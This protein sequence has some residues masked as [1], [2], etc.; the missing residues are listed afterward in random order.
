MN[1]YT[2]PFSAEEI[3]NR[4]NQV[5]INKN[6]IESLSLDTRI[7]SACHASYFNIDKNGI[8]SVKDDVILPDHVFIP[9]HVKGIAVTGMVEGIFKNN[10]DIKE[11]TLCDTITH[12]PNLMCSLAFNLTKINN[13]KNIA[14]I[15]SG[16]FQ[17]TSITELDF[18][19]LQELSIENGSFRNIA[20]LRVIN[21]GDMVQTIPKNTFTNC[22]SLESLKGGQSIIEV[23]ETG[24]KNTPKLKDF[25]QT[26]LSCKAA[27]NS[28]EHSGVQPWDNEQKSAWEQMTFNWD[29]QTQYISQTPITMLD[30]SREKILNSN[31]ESV[32][33][34]IGDTGLTQEYGCSYFSAMHAHSMLQN[35]K[36]NT[37][38]D[39]IND[40]TANNKTMQKYFNK[41]IAGVTPTYPISLMHNIPFF[42]MDLG[43]DVTLYPEG[44]NNQE[45]KNNLTGPIVAAN[46]SKIT[47]ETT[48][49]AEDYAEMCKA[50]QNGSVI[51]TQC[52]YNGDDIKGHYAIIYGINQHG[53]V[54]VLDSAFALAPYETR[55]PLPVDDFYT[56]S[57][58]HSTLA[59]S[60]SKWLVITKPNNGG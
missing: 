16:C 22:M 47:Y 15:G 18:P 7:N 24:F 38:N 32:S 34:P 12:L 39:F 11:L 45:L 37:L 10:S 42:L 58:L 2:L 21:I 8:I 23:G 52:K 1:T 50:L 3:E 20:F 27:K 28:F 41:Q 36:Y 33:P 55:T 30:Q 53:E 25:P 40:I 60:Q 59:S 57:L 17:V 9:S 43:Y 13:T 54:N 35:K 14:T 49:E 26:L 4:L 44:W 31:N 48:I 56:Y 51:L 6:D 29:G 19:N 5:E 46:N